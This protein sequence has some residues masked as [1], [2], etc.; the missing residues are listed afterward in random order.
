MS[1][2][3]FGIE[4]GLDFFA[5]NAQ[6]PSFRILFGSAAPGGD[7]GDQDAAGIGSIYVRVNGASSTIYQKK[8]NAGSVSDWE[9]NGSS[10]AS[11]GAWR[12]EKIRAVTNDTVTAGVARDLVA[13][14]FADDEGTTLAAADFA[15]GEFIIADADGT[16]VLLEVTAISAPSVTF[17][18]PGSAAALASNDTFVAINYLPDSPADQEGQ[19]IVNYNGSVMIKIGDI[20][21]NFA[22]GISLAA[23]YA[24]SSGDISASD[25]V[26][27]AIQKL[28]GNNDAQDTLLGT[29]QGATDL[30]TFTGVTIPDSSSVKAALQA[31]ETA[32]EET[33]QNVD[34]LITLSGVAENATDLGTFTG[35][36][37]SDNTTVKSALQEVETELVDTRDNV[38]DLI[39]LSGVA[40]NSSDFGTFT[41][42]LLADSQTAKQLYQRLEDLLEELKVLEVTGITT[43]ASVDEVPVATVSACKWLVEA[44][45]EAT[46]ANK[47]AIEVYA[48]NNGTLV[49]DT[50]YA[51]LK[52]G[53]NFNLSLSVDI[54][55]GNMRLRAASSTAGVTVRARRLQVTN[56]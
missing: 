40:E 3:F 19:A 16:P 7:T 20:D 50:Q 53:A 56:I 38:D 10:T 4:K 51:K 31:L 32:Y 36:I 12:P 47:Q 46:P 27:S 52:T 2:A 48:L 43:A 22:D 25:T 17:S 39:S 34:D 5:E 24:A 28:D 26:Q 49:D 18:T 30:G 8:A 37:I 15:I 33:D 42:T 14:P 1:R 55:G 11:V 45:E 35:D 13:S 21:W 41:G 23:G 44:F 9:E 6:D 29:S 54:S